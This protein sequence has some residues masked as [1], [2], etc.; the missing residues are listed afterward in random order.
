VYKLLQFIRRLLLATTLLLATIALASIIYLYHYKEQIIERVVSGLSK[1][2]EYPIK[3][4]KV[5]FTILDSFPKLSLVLNEVTIQYPLPNETPLLKANKVYCSLDIRAFLKGKY[6][7]DELGLEHGTIDWVSNKPYPAWLQPSKQP[8]KSNLQADFSIQLTKIQL[9]AMQVAY[10]DTNKNGSRYV[11]QAVNMVAYLNLRADQLYAELH[12]K[13][14]LG[15]ITYQ[16]RT[17][18]KKLPFVLQTKLSYQYKSKRFKVHTS[19]IKSSLG[20]WMLQGHWTN[21]ANGSV[22]M[23]VQGNQISMHDLLTYWSAGYASH[24]APYQVQGTLGLDWRIKKKAGKHNKTHIQGDITLSDS[25][26]KF[27]G[28]DTPIQFGQVKGQLDVPDI[29]NPS[30]SSLALE[31]QAIA[32][33]DSKITGNLKIKDL[34]AF[35]CE[36][37]SQIKLSLGSLAKLF[38]KVNLR[39]VGGFLKGTF[40]LQA[41]MQ[42]LFKNLSIDQVSKLDAKLTTDGVCFT[43]NRVPFV[44]ED[45]SNNLI[46]N[47][48]SLAIK[49]MLGKMGSGEFALQGTLNNYWGFL[50]PDAASVSW[51]GKLYADCMDL[52]ALIASEGKA[53]STPLRHFSIP[54]NW[55]GAWVCDIQKLHYRR[56]Q[57]KQVCGKLLIKDQKLIGQDLS[58]GFAGGKVSLNGFLDTRTDSLH[59]HTLARLQGVELSRLFYSFNNFQQEFL[60]DEHL[61]GTLL[62]DLVLDMYID[63]QGHINWDALKAD[64]AI[65]LH[66]AVLHHFAPLQKLSEYVSEQHLSHLYFA[67]LKNHIQIKNKII[68]IPPMEIYSNI[69][70]I[71]LSGTHSFEGRLAYRLV[72]PLA[73]FKKKSLPQEIDQLEGESLAGLNLYLKL[74][75]DSKNYQV[76]YD[77]EALKADLKSNL[78]KQGKILK[79]IFQ[80]QYVE[81][82]KNKELS[83]QEYFDFD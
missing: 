31:E 10:L 67:A 6:M 65:Q 59:I 68:H 25:Q 62:A 13:V 49:N 42:Q 38:P 34:A 23:T 63:Q 37:Q 80:G 16:G 24:P 43:Y 11:L 44:L 61:G 29:Q 20:S 28:W 32:W 1:K 4:K 64:I 3:I 83:S 18:E 66:Q 79:D 72:V 71:Q 48:H 22:D 30:T 81:K 73:N 46:L 58:L 78:G 8:S 14:D 36:Y 39:N 33:G 54:A 26:V 2:L 35:N 19:Q 76:S 40:Y 82:K 53:A 77:K 41:N 12:G 55:Q 45:Q 9:K 15:P 7:I 5:G 21:Q 57:G 75:G 47:E 17:Y 27:R 52:D 50:K 60:K 51:E 74:E 70:R 69:T 56:F